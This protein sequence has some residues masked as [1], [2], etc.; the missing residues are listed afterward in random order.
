MIEIV[1]L[2]LQAVWTGL[3]KRMQE[4]KDNLIN[5]RFETVCAINAIFNL[6]GKFVHVCNI[7]SWS[8]TKNARGIAA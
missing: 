2:G 1:L 6:E 7:W 3:F 5:D 4:R 8:N